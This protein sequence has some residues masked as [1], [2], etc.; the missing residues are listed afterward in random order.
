MVRS[1]EQ[2]L[3]MSG[4]SLLSIQDFPG[5]GTAL[6]GM[7]DSHLESKSYDFA[8]PNRFKSIFNQVNVLASFDKYTYSVGDVL[9]FD[10]NVA[11]YSKKD[12][13]DTVCYVLKGKD[14][15]FEG[16]TESK[17]IPTGQ[18]TFI[19]HIE[20]PLDKFSKS[21]RLDLVLTVGEYQNSY[22]IWVYVDKQVNL[23][24]E[25]K[26]CRT[27]DANFME[28]IK[29]GGIVYLCPESTK[30]HLPQSIQGE[31]STDFW[32]VGTFPLQQGGMGY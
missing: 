21:S 23:K 28:A 29:E 1:F 2:T 8:Q 16:Q 9:R 18:L 3:F 5:Q 20:I 4:I 10:I 13:T 6:V 31:F 30:D 24:E 32:S 26:V 14:F 25:I 11:N 22:P 19:Q 7:L 12:F 17:L 27:L 15:I